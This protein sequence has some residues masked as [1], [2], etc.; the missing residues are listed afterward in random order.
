MVLIQKKYKTRKNI[1][2]LEKKI[3]NKNLNIKFNIIKFEDNSIYQNKLKKTDL[4]DDK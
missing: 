2:K 1:S 4:S 3:C